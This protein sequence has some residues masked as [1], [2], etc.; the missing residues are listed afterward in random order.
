MQGF[1]GIIKMKD[2]ILFG[3]ERERSKEKWDMKNQSHI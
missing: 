3:D 2:N 1:C